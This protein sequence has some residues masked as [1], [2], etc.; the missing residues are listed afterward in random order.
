MVVVVV[1]ISPL[2]QLMVI[3][4]MLEV[5]VV[6]VIVMLLSPLHQLL[7]IMVMH[8]VMVV[9]VIIMIPPPAHGDRGH[10]PTHGGSS[11]VNLRS[12]SW[13]S[14]SWLWLMVVIVMPPHP[15]RGGFG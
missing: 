6:V 15:A 10:A 9:V 4:V 2:H 11:H 13:W 12:S 1:L 3:M 8:E 14:Q 5:M 7:V